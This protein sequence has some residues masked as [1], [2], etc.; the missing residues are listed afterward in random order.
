M[1]VIIRPPL[2]FI[3][4]ITDSSC[5]CEPACA[6]KDF[7]SCGTQCCYRIPHGLSDYHYE[8][9][10]NNSQMANGSSG[11][12]LGKSGGSAAYQYTMSSEVGRGRTGGGCCGIM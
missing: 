5:T 12:G 4:G 2:N 9:I 1:M 7:R 6:C 10:T 3:C 11:M 8:T